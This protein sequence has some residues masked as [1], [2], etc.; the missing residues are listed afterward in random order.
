ME[1]IILWALDIG[2]GLLLMTWG[3]FTTFQKWGIEKQQRFK[4]IAIY[5]IFV[6]LLTALIK[7]VM[8]AMVIAAILVAFVFPI[9]IHSWRALD[10]WGLWLIVGVAFVLGTNT[11][12]EFIMRII[13]IL[14]L[15]GAFVLI[16]QVFTRK[17]YSRFGQVGMLS[18]LFV[19]GAIFLCSQAGEKSIAYWLNIGLILLSIVGFAYVSMKKKSNAKPLL[20]FDLDGTLIDSQPLVFETFRQVFATLKPGYPLS[21]EELYSFFG[22]TLETTFLRYFPEDEVESVIEVYQQIN[23]KLHATYLKEMPYAL[24]TIAALDE[25]GYVLGI[26][27]NKRHAVVELGLEQSKLKPYMRAV[28]GKEDQP[29]CKP[30]PDGLIHAAKQMGY[31]LDEVLY[32][33]DNAADIQAAKGTAFYSVG[34]T[35]DTVQ[36]QSLLNAKPCAFIDD[37]RKIKDLLKEDRIWID[38]SIW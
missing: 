12:A 20:L 15:L 9:E 28:Y 3:V 2:F 30:K 17:F 35:L 25:Q 27:S 34:Y 1:N 32:F 21:D 38:K 23:R 6:L 36:K 5:W 18:I 13:S 14:I 33:G 37:L 16:R 11:K 8:V 24:E 10:A 31:K 26:V 19:C 22:P 4:A 7:Q 29:A